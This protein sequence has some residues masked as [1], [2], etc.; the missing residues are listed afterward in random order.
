MAKSVILMRHGESEANAGG[1]WQG[2]GSSPLTAMGRR[3]A[4]RAGM[5]LAARSIALVESSDLQRCVDTAGAAGFVPD[6]RRGWREGDV[7]EWEGRSG[8]YVKT[9]FG[10][11]LER[12]HYDPDMPVGVTGESPRQ[13]AERGYR[14][15]HELV[16]RL[17]EGSTALVVTHAGLIGALL[18]RLLDLPRDR[19]RI[20]VLSNTAL[21]ELTF[22]AGRLA[23]RTFNDAAHLGHIAGWSEGL[24]QAGAVVVD[25]VRHGTSYANLESGG[26]SR[27]DGLHSRGR[28]QAT[29]VAGRIGKVDEVYSS[30]LARASET[31]ELAFGRSPIPV[32]E[33]G[34]IDLGE[35]NADSWPEMGLGT[36]G[37]SHRRGAGDI[38]PASTGETWRQVQQR[39]SS[40]FG[41]LPHLHPGQRVAVVSHGGVIRAYAGSVLG[42]GSRKARLLVS[43]ANASVTRVV[44]PESRRPV[45][46][47]Y[48]TT[49]HL[50]G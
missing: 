8:D 4:E 21:C 22:R 20:G 50:E 44:V 24:R 47:A 15:L 16:D 2:T 37:F 5:A 27:R 3:Q 14:A 17:D 41:T 6:S 10:E 29:K 42:F 34:E 32:P 25:L 49:G 11:E 36:H 48:N 31:A 30:P 43:L 12:L 9:R 18:R 45:L 46:A 26:W 35:C 23:M 7:G 1:L 38:G 40:F 13:V 19:R 39:A 28:A 33:L